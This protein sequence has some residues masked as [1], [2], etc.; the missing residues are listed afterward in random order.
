MSGELKGLI[1]LNLTACEN[2]N[3]D[4]SIPVVINIDTLYIINSS[5]KYYNDICY[6]YISSDGTDISILDRKKDFVNN[7]LTVYKENCDFIDH[8]YIIKKAIC[9]CKVKLDTNIKK[10]GI[11]INKDKLYKRFTNIKNIANIDVLK[12]YDLIFILDAYKYNYANLITIF[13]ILLLTL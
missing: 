7:N 10:V 12:C 9:S 3:I 13:V 8:N 5:N 1:K 11:E 2:S 6:T 4:L